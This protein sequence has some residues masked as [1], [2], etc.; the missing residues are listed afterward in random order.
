MSFANWSQF[1]YYVVGDQV[2]EN[3]ILYIAKVNLAPSTR[4]PSA[5]PSSWTNLGSTSGGATGPTGPSGGPVGPSGPTGPRGT[6]GTNGAAGATGPTGVGSM[7]ATGPAG[8]AGATGP[9]GAGST[10][11]TGPTGNDGATG[12][13]GETG[14][15][16]DVGE[17]GPQGPAGTAGLT[18]INVDGTLL[19]GAEGVIQFFAG[20]NTTITTDVDNQAI[21]FTSSGGG[22]GINA[23]TAGTG[24]G[25]DSADPAAPIVST[26]LDANAGLSLSVDNAIFINTGDGLFVDGNVLKNSGVIAVNGVNGLVDL[27]SS[28]SS[29][30]ITPDAVANTI[31]LQAVAG[32]V[33][34]VVAGTGIVVSSVDP[35][36]P[37]VS[38]NLA[39]ES[40]LAVDVD[41][42]LYINTGTGLS[43]TGGDLVNTGV[44]ALNA[45]DGVM[46]LISSDSTITITP[47]ADAKTINLQS[48]SGGSGGQT[49]TYP[50]AGTYTYTVPI[51]AGQEAGDPV[52]VQ[53][54]MKGGG[55]GGGAS[56]KIYDPATDSVS[57]AGGGGGGEGEAAIGPLVF[58][59]TLIMSAGEVID[60]EVGVGG[61]GGEYGGINNGDGGDGGACSIDSSTGL[62][63][64]AITV[65]GGKGGGGGIIVAGVK[66]A[67]GD[68][69]AGNGGG[70]SAWSTTLP[71]VSAGDGNGTGFGGW[72]RWRRRWRWRWSWGHTDY[73]R[74]TG[75]NRIRSGWWWSQCIRH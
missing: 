57:T 63:G 36:A 13:S 68:G 44:I 15:K 7:G 24:I 39:A 5:D 14:P 58:P 35:A 29:I 10:G 18:T 17:T 2:V 32:I 62:N 6:N 21:T 23:I 55:G 64:G 45:V 67:G 72:W 50:T 65:A 33:G 30:T 8:N 43:R 12:P 20:A 11:A 60:L 3:S 53:V 40:G 28:D 49:L 70:G 27:I 37:V 66:A 19:T 25:V 31:N 47:D 42:A 9:A 38:V 69:G 22:G 56:S 75:W 51:P 34:S 74:W 4:P 61:D 1:A 41:N 71:S 73:S 26:L 59:I 54:Y 48:I 46:N 52:R 16:G